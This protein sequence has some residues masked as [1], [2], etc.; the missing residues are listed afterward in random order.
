MGA[1][2]TSAV[3][4][5]MGLLGEDLEHGV[6]RQAEIAPVVIAILQAP[7]CHLASVAV[8]F[9]YKAQKM[10]PEFGKIFGCIIYI[11]IH[12]YIYM[13]MYIYNFI[14]VYIIIIYV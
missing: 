12:M 8:S 6:E 11:Y 7:G 2:V 14:Y 5:A 1:S 10:V 4:A 3:A 9:S 13:Y